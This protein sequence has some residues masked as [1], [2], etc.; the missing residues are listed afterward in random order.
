M[1]DRKYTAVWPAFKIVLYCSWNHVFKIV[2]AFKAYMGVQLIVEMY[3][4]VN[5]I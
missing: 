1:A 2:I 3:I 5:I 4:R